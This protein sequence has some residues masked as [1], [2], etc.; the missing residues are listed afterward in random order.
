MPTLAPNSWVQGII[1]SQAP[2]AGTSGIHHYVKLRDSHLQS[3]RFPHTHTH[4][5][6]VH[7]LKHQHQET[8]GGSLLFGGWSPWIQTVPARVL[9]KLLEEELPLEVP[10]VL[11]D[12]RRQRLS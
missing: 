4:Q 12:L 10:Q 11:Q 7:P 9:L 8:L 6:N 1:K 3:C 5:Y 2:S